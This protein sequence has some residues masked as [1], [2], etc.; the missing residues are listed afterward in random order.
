MFL[1]P[2]FKGIDI[3]FLIQYCRVYG[4]LGCTG[5][6]E[7]NDVVLHAYLL[8]YSMEQSPS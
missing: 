1:I 6:L 2:A 8:T 7:V 5:F 3:C 4:V